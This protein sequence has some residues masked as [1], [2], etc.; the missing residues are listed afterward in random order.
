YDTVDYMS[1]ITAGDWNADG[2][3]DLAVTLLHGWRILLGNG[4]GGFQ[5]AA[6]YGTQTA[7]GITHADLNGD[8]TADLAV[9]DD[10]GS[11]IRVLMA[12]GAPPD[13]GVE[14]CLAIPADAGA[15][16]DAPGGGADAG[17][18]GPDGGGLAPG[19]S[20]FVSAG[21]YPAARAPRAVVP[22]DF[23]HDG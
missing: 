22:G 21:E 10:D 19:S 3:T 20:F 4:R 1:G 9:G 23:N 18:C 12:G 14:A 11:A 2:E 16:G 15:G 13:G 5:G 17:A 6:S 7:A 8:G